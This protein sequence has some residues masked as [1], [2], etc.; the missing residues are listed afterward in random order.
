MNIRPPTAALLATAADHRKLFSSLILTPIGAAWWLLWKER[1][2][3]W[4][5]RLNL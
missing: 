1:S 4:E 2:G 3:D 5:I